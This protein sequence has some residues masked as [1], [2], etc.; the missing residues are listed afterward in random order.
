MGPQ[1]FSHRIGGRTGRHAKALTVSVGTRAKV[2]FEQGVFDINWLTNG[3]RVWVK[4]SPVGRCVTVVQTVLITLKPDIGLQYVMTLQVTDQFEP[5]M[6]CTINA[7]RENDELCRGSWTTCSTSTRFNDIIL[8]CSL[9][10]ID[11][12][13]VIGMDVHVCYE[14]ESGRT[15][16]FVPQAGLPGSSL[17]GMQ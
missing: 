11:N 12:W 13:S 6:F 15:A 8:V 17:M 1:T 9:Q 5:K 10:E 14:L 2:G 16:F 3:I 4:G 7:N